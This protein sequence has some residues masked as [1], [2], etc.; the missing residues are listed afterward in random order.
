[1]SKWTVAGFA[2]IVAVSFV[3]GQS[4]AEEEGGGGGM[5]MPAW[6]KKGEQHADLAKSVGE[7]TIAT[8]MW[9][10]PGTPPQKGTATGKREM[11]LNGFYLQETFKMNFMGMPYEGRLIQGYDTVRKRYVVVWTD[12]MSPVPHISYGEMKDGK[13]EMKGE[14]PDHTGKLEGRRMVIENPIGDK[15]TV[16]FFAVQPDGTERMDMRLVYASK[17]VK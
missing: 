11:I 9:M 12:N 14:A 13:I 15:S 3:I 6:M 5:Q 16:T 8:E 4:F 10:A 1:M 2:A 7:F 17:K